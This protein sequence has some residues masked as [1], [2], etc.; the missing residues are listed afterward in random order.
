VSA[1]WRYAAEAVFFLGVAYALVRWIGR[2]LRETSGGAS[3]REATFFAEVIKGRDVPAGLAA[4]GASAGPLPNAGRPS[5]VSLIVHCPACGMALT[6]VP[7]T[8][9]FV[10]DCEGCARRVRVRGDGPGRISVVVDDRGR[11]AE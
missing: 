5:T 9:P 10:A 8:L 4:P 2:T 7:Q 6:P 1:S 11:R 3:E